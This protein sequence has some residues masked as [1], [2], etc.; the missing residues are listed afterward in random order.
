MLKVLG[1]LLLV[2]GILLCFTII[3]AGFGIPMTVV[4]ALLLIA[5]ALYA[6]NKLQRDA[7]SMARDYQ[8]SA[9]D[10]RGTHTTLNLPNPMHRP[11]EP[12]AEEGKRPGKIV[13]SMFGR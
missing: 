13:R 3:F 4:G 1:W 10:D 9:G 5:D 12:P 2:V 8:E 6:R 7:Q 11:E